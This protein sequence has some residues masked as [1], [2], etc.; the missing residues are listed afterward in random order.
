M[1]TLAEK[2]AY[3]LSWY[4]RNKKRVN[5]EKRARWSIM[6]PEEKEKARAAQ[7]ASHQRHRANRL[8]KNNANYRKNPEAYKARARRW[9]ANHPESVAACTA[10]RRADLVGATPHWVDR[11]AV[12]IIYAEA[13]ARTRETGIPHHVDHR[14]PLRGK[15]FNGLHVPWNLQILTAAQNIAKSNLTPC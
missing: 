6:S 15:G 12:R 14:Y 4:H 10:K 5:D 7:A 11:Q 2:A 8:A 3:Q 9:G 13:A 1:K